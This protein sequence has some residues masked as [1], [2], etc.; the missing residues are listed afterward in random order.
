MGRVEQLGWGLLFFGLPWG[1]GTIGLLLLMISR[2]IGRLRRRA[3]VQEA[4]GG[5]AAAGTL[6][7]LRKLLYVMILFMGI[8]ALLSSNPL[9]ASL[10]TLA[11]YLV[12]R[13]AFLAIPRLIAA[14]R[15]FRGMLWVF[16]ASAFLS[17][18][19]SLYRHFFEG[20]IQAR[21]LLKEQ[22]AFGTLMIAGFFI[23]LG[24][25]FTLRGNRWRYLLLPVWGAT[26]TGLI[27]SLSRG[28]WAGFI[29]GGLA[30]VFAV[31][32]RFPTKRALAITAVF[33]VLLSL[34]VSLVMWQVTPLRNRMNSVLDLN[35]GEGRFYLWTST[36]RMST[37]SFFFGV[38]TGLY[39]FVYPLYRLPEGPPDNPPPPFAH[40]LFLQQ[41]A[42]QGLIGAALFVAIVLAILYR[43][44]QGLRFRAPWAWGG[45]AAFIGY[46]V[47]DQVDNILYDYDMLILFWLL[48][49]MFLFAPSIAEE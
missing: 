21:T 11:F 14:A 19:Y 33:L 39:P 15:F 46:L 35:S 40:N 38:G 44:I 29:A 28:S 8:S 13:F 31:V 49:G 26:L 32:K 47:H 5:S 45:L 12:I 2:A 34:A 7:G 37:E 22:N 25:F 16:A 17:S 4:D 36:L 1:N 43:G 41:L 42:E 3:G 6:A 20:T 48:A 30:F 18:L 24:L 27:F 10:N 23:A 9:I